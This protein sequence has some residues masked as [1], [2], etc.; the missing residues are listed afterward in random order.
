MTPTTKTALK[1][2]FILGLAQMAWLYL[3]YYLG[4]HTSGI[5]VFQWFVLAWLLLTLVGFV[6]ILR[7]VRRRAE[8]G[9]W[10]WRWGMQAGFLAA[11]VTGLLAVA[12][13]AGYHTTIHPEWPSYM[14]DQTRAH[15]TALGV[16]PA[17]VEQMA[18]QARKT[19][20]LGNYALQ[21]SLSTF[22]TGGFL[23]AFIMLFLRKPPRK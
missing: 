18:E 20:S 14:V 4:L 3:A 16:S 23:S 8:P 21:S 17:E 12:A 9:Q 10:G 1:G 7:A 15:F 5:M 2:G 13:Q 19:F 22:V 6:L 11:L